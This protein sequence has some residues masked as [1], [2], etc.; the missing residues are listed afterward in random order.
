ML[1]RIL[2]Q[3]FINR[4]MIAEEEREIY[5]YGFDITIYTIWSTAALLLLGLLL[6]QFFPALILVFGFYTFQTT[7]GGYHAKTHLRCF[8]TMVSGLLV[9]LSSVFIKDRLVLLWSLLSIGALLL[10]LVPLVLHPNKSYLEAERK[11]LT[12]KS[13]AVTLSVLVCAVVLNS[14][15][16]R[17]LYAFA[18][19]FLL[20][21]ISRIAGKIAYNFRSS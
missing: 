19:V 21:G 18:T 3:S 9:G 5:E 12:I 10:L 20:A 2:T 4:D 7:G 16:S 8:L 6:R 14:F 13:I 1:Y 17:M 11:R 15:W